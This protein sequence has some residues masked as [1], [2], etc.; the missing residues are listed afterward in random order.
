M[1][2]IMAA[3]IILTA[4]GA[5]AEGTAIKEPDRTGFTYTAEV[6]DRLIDV[7][8]D[9]PLRKGREIAL[10]SVELLGDD[11][12]GVE[13]IDSIQVAD[14]GLKADLLLG[15]PTPT[16]KG[17]RKYWN[18]QVNR[19]PVEGA[20]LRDGD[21]GDAGYRL[22]IPLEV[23]H[24]GRWHRTHVRVNYVEDGAPQ[25]QDLPMEFVLCTPEGLDE[26]G[27]C[28]LPNLYDD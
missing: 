16:D 5:P 13:V 24:P 3:A 26:D 4:C 7:F 9:L 14:G 25:R 21:E 11:F 19:R 18:S 2:T 27:V 1:L 20:V 15:Y 12:G 23:V 8:T 17:D 28:P 10:E 6:G 22:I